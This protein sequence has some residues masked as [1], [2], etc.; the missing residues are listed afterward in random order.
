MRVP[1][2]FPRPGADVHALA[3]RAEDRQHLGRLRPG[4]AEPVRDA[5]VELRDLA[6]LHDEVMLG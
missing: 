2:P 3:L 5:R 4:A 6:G 1:G